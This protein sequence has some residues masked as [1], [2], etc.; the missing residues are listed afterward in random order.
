MRIVGLTR[1]LADAGCDVTLVARTLP[2]ELEGHV[3]F[4]ALA[5]PAARYSLALPYAAFPVL[6]SAL[7][8]LVHDRV[9]AGFLRK[10]RFDLIHCHQSD[11]GFRLM[12]LGRRLSVPVAID[13]HG[14]MR[15]QRDDLSA[16][17]RPIQAAFALR[18]ESHL[19]RWA[20]GLV[21]RSQAEAEYVAREFGVAPER[22]HAVP[23]GA[24][25]GDVPLETFDGEATALR[26]RLG[27]AAGRVVC[28]GG[29][30]KVQGGVQVLVECIHLVCARRPEVTFVLVGDGVLMPEVRRSLAGL[31][32][33]AVR[34]VGRQDRRSFRL[35]QRMADVVVTPEIRNTYNELAPPLKLLDCLA[36]GRPTVA[37][38]I[39]SHEAII[40]DGRNGFLVEAGDAADLARGIE[41]ALDAGDADAI[42]RRGRRTVEERFSW[43]RSAEE[44]TT[45]FRAMID[46]GSAESR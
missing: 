12:K 46:V 6:F 39:A 15:L 44:A 25:L 20:A 41:R 2:S 37:T 8:L 34:V 7:R 40:E 16:S 31:R 1:A 36:S 21:V 29:E 18:A 4:Q 10:G 24:D 3:Q 9:L 28:F 32:S 22:C 23:D 11:A 27:L 14:I 45:V 17:R 19:F 13:V 38:R 5:G 42:G 43:R 33:G 30:F 35:N 26:E